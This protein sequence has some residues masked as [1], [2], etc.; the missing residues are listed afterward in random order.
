[1][2]SELHASAFGHAGVVEPLAL[3]CLVDSDEFTLESDF[4]TGFGFADV[5]CCEMQDKIVVRHPESAVVFIQFGVHLFNNI[6]SPESA[7]PVPSTVPFET[8][9]NVTD[10]DQLMI[11]DFAHF[12]DCVSVSTLQLVAHVLGIFLIGDESR[13]CSR[14]QV[15]LVLEVEHHT[16]K[17][18]RVNEGTGLLIFEVVQN[19]LKACEV[20]ESFIRMALV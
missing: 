3:Y 9:P 13:S 5:E 17:I 12:K 7:P 16:E 8:S 15:S 14:Q 19:R 20:L 18:S 6:I 11:V 1:M 10:V 4:V 2:N